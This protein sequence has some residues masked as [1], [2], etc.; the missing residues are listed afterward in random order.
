MIRH[1]LVLYLALVA[2]ILGPDL[3]PLWVLPLLLVSVC[4]LTRQKWIGLVGFLLFGLIT[5]GRIEV[6]FNDMYQLAVYTLGIIIPSLIMMELILSGKPYRL[7]KLSPGPIMV[8]AGLISGFII[9]L[10]I[11]VRISRVGVYL[12]SD[13]IVQVFVLMSLSILFAAPVILGGKKGSDRE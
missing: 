2:L 7:E 9:S 5:L 8:T 4:F 1:L 11:I 6:S 3:N 13:L 10:F 12:N